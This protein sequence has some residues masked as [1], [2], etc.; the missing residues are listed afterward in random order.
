MKKK[1]IALCGLL[2]TCTAHAWEA[3]V[4]DI[5]QHGNYVAVYLSPDPGAGSC[6]QSQPYLLVVDDSA[7]AKQRFGLI[8]TALAT[9]HKIGGYDDGCDTAIWAQSRPLIHRLVLR[10]N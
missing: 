3:N 8:L 9:G 1:L 7:A 2:A 6:S 5:L 10:S 4:T